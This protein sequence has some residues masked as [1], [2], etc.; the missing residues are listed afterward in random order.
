MSDF[1]FPVLIYH[2]NSAPQNL[3]S[4]YCSHLS[5]YTLLTCS[6][7]YSSLRRRL[8]RNQVVK[9]A[10]Y[11]IFRIHWILEFQ[12]SLQC[13]ST[14]YIYICMYLSLFTFQSPF[15]DAAYFVLLRQISYFALLT[16]RISSAARN[17]SSLYYSHLSS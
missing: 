14:I 2:I 5:P 9:F 12:E 16:Y 15:Q 8:C 1:A 11:S 4:L 3:S 7:F 10:S 17:S 6:S 13:I